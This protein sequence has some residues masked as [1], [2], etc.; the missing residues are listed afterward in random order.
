MSIDLSFAVTYQYPDR[1][2]GIT[3]PLLLRAGGTVIQA[4]AKV[5]TG[6][7]C[8]IFSQELG[9]KLGLEIE[10]GLYKPMGSLT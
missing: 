3:I 6:S 1:P 5:D 4:S 2:D 10:R 8:C 7:E 9:V